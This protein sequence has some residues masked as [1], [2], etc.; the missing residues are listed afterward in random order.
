MDLRSLISKLDTIDQRKLLKEAEDV[1]EAIQ[2]I[3]YSDV[4][5]LAKTLPPPK[6]V[7]RATALG[8]LARDNSLPGLFDPFTNKFVNANGQFAKIGA[9]SSEIDT[10][11]SKGL[12]PLGAET[13]NWGM[14]Q[15]RAAAQ[16]GNLSA[17]EVIKKAYRAD[18]IMD[19][20]LPKLAQPGIGQSSEAPPAAASAKHLQLGKQEHLKMKVFH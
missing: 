20:A 16:A 9:Y 11:K 5:A 2:G 10:L 3:Q 18:A 15:D 6:D 13:S 19:L 12:M 4:E 8:K 7:E 17:Q 14:G 1:L